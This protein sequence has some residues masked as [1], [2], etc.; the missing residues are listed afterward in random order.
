MP[1]DA[2][3]DDEVSPDPSDCHCHY[4]FLRI[5]HARITNAA[6]NSAE[7]KTGEPEWC[8]PEAASKS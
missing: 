4:F 8:G 3:N 1:H 2:T 6:K 5:F 7:I